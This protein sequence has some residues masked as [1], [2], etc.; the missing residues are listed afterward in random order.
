[1]RWC[2]CWSLPRPRAMP[3]LHGQRLRL[4]DDW[5]P[6]QMLPGL[7]APDFSAHERLT[8]TTYAVGAAG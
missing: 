5:Q 3:W 1:M 7:E 2:R 8:R 4:P 6:L